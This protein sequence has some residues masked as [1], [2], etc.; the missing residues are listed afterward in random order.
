[1]F[2]WAIG[3]SECYIVVAPRGVVGTAVARTPPVGIPG[4]AR[5]RGGFLGARRT[6]GASR[7][8]LS[9]PHPGNEIVSR[10]VAATVALLVG[11]TLVFDLPWPL[12]PLVQ[13][14]AAR[15]PAGPRLSPMALLA[16]RV[17]LPALGNP[18]Q[19][20]TAR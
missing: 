2:T 19:W 10:L 5:L 16:S 7:K 18:R 13:G 20:A 4:R 1:M 14:F 17:L 11:S 12:P 9:Y 6:P 15:V 8:A 3:G